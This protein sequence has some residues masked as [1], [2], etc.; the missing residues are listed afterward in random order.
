[1][2]LAS[3]G[4]PREDYERMLRGADRGRRRAHRDAAALAGRV[5]GGVREAAGDQ[6]A[7][8]ISRRS[9]TPISPGRCRRCSRT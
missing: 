9:S 4:T 1:M 6:A 3:Y 2:G 8:A 5:A 7:A